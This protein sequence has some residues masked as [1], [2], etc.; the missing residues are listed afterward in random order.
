[1]QTFLALQTFEQRESKD[2]KYLIK[3]MS[4]NLD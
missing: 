2:K 4:C 1:L 3:K